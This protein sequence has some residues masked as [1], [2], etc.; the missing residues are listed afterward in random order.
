MNIQRVR[1]LTTFILHTEI[2]HVYTDLAYITGMKHIATHMIPALCEAVQPW[3]LEH[4]PAKCHIQN[5]YDTSNEDIDIRPM[6]EDE[7]NRY[8]QNVKYPKLP[9]NIIVITHETS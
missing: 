3:L 8:V 2:D 4:T 6:T 5:L 7:L 1:N 9:D